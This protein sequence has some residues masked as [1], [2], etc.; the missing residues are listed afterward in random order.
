MEYKSIQELKSDFVKG[1]ISELPTEITI[2]G[3]KYDFLNSTEYQLKEVLGNKK[4]K[5]M[6]I[7]NLNKN[8][9]NKEAYAEKHTDADDEK[10]FQDRIV[11]VWANTRMHIRPV[12][13][14]FVPKQRIGHIMVREAE[15]ADERIIKNKVSIVLTGFN[16]GKSIAAKVDTGAAISSLDAN[17]VNVNRENGT[18]SF[19]FGDRTI[20]MSLID[21]QAVKTADGGVE[22]RPVVAF[23]VTLPNE[24]STKQNR[25]VKKVQFNLNDRSGMP[26]KILLGQ[27]FIKAG[28]FVVMGKET[29]DPKMVEGNDFNWDTLQD[30]FEGIE[31]DLQ[32]YVYM[33]SEVA[34]HLLTLIREQF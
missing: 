7:Y 5:P 20:S 32:D 2:D 19:S 22:N 18:V 26:D 28:D 21:T 4:K 14:R 27:N 15:I 1:K 16:G 25:I 30:M 11:L 10:S 12:E 24:D 29:D 6:A 13:S 3:V 23:D 9:E 8:A 31:D 33:E 34:K 17:N